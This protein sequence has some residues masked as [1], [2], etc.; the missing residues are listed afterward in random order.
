[1]NLKKFVSEIQKF[2]EEDIRCLSDLVMCH[3]KVILI[4]NGGSNSVCSHIAQDY[5]KMLGVPSLSFSD[6]SRLTCY[7][8]D[9]GME[10]AYSQFIDEFSTDT[11][12]IILI[13]SS[14]NSENIHRCASL[15][16]DR[17]LNT[18]L[19][20]G[21]QADNR[22]RKDFAVDDNVKL[23]VWV[24]SSDFGIVECA[25]QVFLHSIIGFIEGA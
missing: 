23:S 6:P 20:T 9:Y 5:T 3:E 7:I 21:F 10:N 12:L 19:L 15:C 24:D 8:N 1:M 13:S 2:S 14:G 18:V 11:T 17:N 16:R 4:G 22:V 25:H